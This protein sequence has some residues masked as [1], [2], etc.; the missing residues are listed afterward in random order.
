MVNAGILQILWMTK[1]INSRT[2]NTKDDDFDDNLTMSVNK[3]STPDSG[4]IK[5]NSVCAL[6]DVAVIP[7]YLMLFLPPQSKVLLVVAGSS[8]ASV[9]HFLSFWQSH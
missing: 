4:R 2:T 1:K 9:L 3:S 8:K 7:F 5:S 6:L